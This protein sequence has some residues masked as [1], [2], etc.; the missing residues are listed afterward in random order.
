MGT[1]S[2]KCIDNRVIVPVVVSHP[3]P[4]AR[5]SEGTTA[6]VDTGADMT[7]LRLDVAQAL[8]LPLLDIVRFSSVS[9][10]SFCPIFS[11]RVQ[12][13]SRNYDTGKVETA[14]RTRTP[15]SVCGASLPP[16]FPPC[17]VGMDIISQGWFTLAGKLGEFVLAF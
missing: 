4:K 16:D 1:I 15:I 6:M 7:T 14:Y 13:V 3:N 10:T 8:N 5:K 12:L 9:S 17:L 11:A 2:L